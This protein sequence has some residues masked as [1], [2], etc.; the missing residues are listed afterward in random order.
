MKEIIFLPHYKMTGLKINPP[1]TTLASGA[2]LKLIP[3]SSL[4]NCLKDVQCVLENG[5]TID[6]VTATLVPSPSPQD[7]IFNLAL[8][9]TFIQYSVDNIVH[10]YFDNPSTP[11]MLSSPILTGFFTFQG[12]STSYNVSYYWDV[13]TSSVNYIVLRFKIKDIIVNPSEPLMFSANINI[14]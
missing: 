7:N 3:N 12:S 9:G 4:P 13:V 10:V 6:W 11:V 2:L 8:T 14:F 1:N 5:G